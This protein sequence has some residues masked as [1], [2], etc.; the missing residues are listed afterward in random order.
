MAR[1]A[2]I[3]IKGSD[4]YYHVMSRTVGQ[5]FLLRNSEKDKFVEIMFELSKLFFLKIIGFSIMS[6]HFHILIKMENGE[7]YSDEQISNRVKRYYKKNL[8]L[9]K[10]EIDNYREKL[11]D[12]SNCIKLLK[13]KF[14]LWYNRRNN[15][16]GYFWSDRFKSVLIESGESLLNCLAYIDLNPV[17]ADIIS[18]P[19]KYKWSS[20]YYRSKK[21][22]HTSLS[23]DGICLNSENNLIADYLRYLYFVGNIPEESSGR[24]YKSPESGNTFLIK[25][26]IFRNKKNSFSDCLVMGSLKFVK[27]SY[28]MFGDTILIK[29]NKEAY[30]T[31]FSE[32]IFSV[33]RKYEK[34]FH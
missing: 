9:S 13:Q 22:I 16:K 26:G 8:V 7:S 19:E 25:R 11:G 18:L 21:I 32:N 30:I 17:R 5:D 4:A 6:N 24:E 31:E 3:K 15:R 28:K 1:L 2:R 14:S 20:V 29:Q 27:N 34:S 33:R 12:I 23:F 10:C